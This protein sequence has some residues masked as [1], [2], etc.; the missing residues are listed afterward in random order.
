MLDQLGREGG[1]SL[2]WSIYDE[3][4]ER[5]WRQISEEAPFFKEATIALDQGDNWT[6]IKSTGD[7]ARLSTVNLADSV[8]A[9]IVSSIEDTIA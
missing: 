5:K 9:A 8:A 2:Y 7:V 1:P 6:A 3:T 4:Y